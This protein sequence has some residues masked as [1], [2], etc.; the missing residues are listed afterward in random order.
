MLVHCLDPETFGVLF[1]ESFVYERE[2]FNKFPMFLDNWPVLLKHFVGVFTPLVTA[3]FFGVGR[4]SFSQCKAVYRT[5][6]T[7]STLIISIILCF[8]VVIYP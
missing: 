3:I 2:Y 5:C 7:L 4:F 6:V 1:A 8:S